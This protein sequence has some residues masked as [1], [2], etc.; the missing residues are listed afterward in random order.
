[1]RLTTYSDY[2]LRLLMFC[3]LNPDRTVT[4]AEVAKAY[5]V[6]KNHLMKIAHELSQMGYLTATRGRNGGL[7]L[8]RPARE[9]TVGDVV[10]MT[11][12]HSF[13]VECCDPISNT[14]IISPACSLKRVLL[15]ALEDF[16]KRLDKSTIA[17]LVQQPGRMRALFAVQPPA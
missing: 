6:S 3:A 4:I 1:M 8:A 13:L 7:C 17:D 14:C 2:A 15:G 16:Y 9:I 11:E 10:R 5:N 12:A